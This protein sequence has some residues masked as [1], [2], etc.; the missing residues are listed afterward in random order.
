MSIKK[1]D[2]Q[3]KPFYTHYG[4]NF[5]RVF[6]IIL[7]IFIILLAIYIIKFSIF[8]SIITILI[9]IFGL[10]FIRFPKI[11]LYEE[12]FEI[13]KKSLISKFTEK[14]LFIYRDLKEVEFSKGYTDWHYL[15]VIAIFGSGGPG[16]NSK[17][18]QMIIKTL[19][20]KEIYFNRFGRKIEFQKTIDK[21]NIKISISKQ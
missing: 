18:D 12:R 4:K 21:I 6:S 5:W 14:D 1:I 20:E 17:A 15:I 13:I 8:L 2:N 11:N 9:C 16:G 7:L 10:F 3:E 19:N